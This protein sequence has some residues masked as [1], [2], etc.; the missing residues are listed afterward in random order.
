MEEELKTIFDPFWLP[1]SKVIADNGA[2]FQN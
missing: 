1:T 2:H